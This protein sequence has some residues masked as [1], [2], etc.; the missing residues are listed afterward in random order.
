MNKIKLMTAVMMIL[1]A[2]VMTA[3]TS[4]EPAVTEQTTETSPVET[5]TVT[6]TE[7]ETVTT[8][9]EPVTESET[10]TVTTEELPF[11]DTPENAY[12]RLT[13]SFIQPDGNEIAPDDYAGV[14]SYAGTLFVALTVSEPTEYYTELFDGYTC[15]RYR[16]VKRSFNELTEISRKAA[17]LLEP[18]FGVAEC[19][20]DVPS[21]KAAVSI[22]E[23]DPK[24]AQNYLKTL[25]DIGF[26]LHDVEITMAEKTDG[27]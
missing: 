6:E 23:G 1:A 21:N 26:E 22:I 19:Y 14:Y 25:T 15:V 3:C 2:A 8:T 13:R 27:E 17:E 4:S 11:E 7:T 9:A 24:S 16:T 12:E 5:T 20:I 10:T 18:E